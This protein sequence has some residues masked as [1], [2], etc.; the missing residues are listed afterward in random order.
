MAKLILNPNTADVQIID[1][2]QPAML[3]GSA[4][5]ADIRIDDESL[6]GPCARIETKSDGCYIINLGSG[7][8]TVNGE[9]VSFQRLQ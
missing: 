9:D 1:L 4:Q 2:D 3:I 8:L 6:A 7:G 5:D